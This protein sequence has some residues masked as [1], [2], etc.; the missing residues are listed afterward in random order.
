M[1][2]GF[3]SRLKRD[4]ERLGLRNVRFDWSHSPP[5]IIGTLRYVT[6]TQPFA[7]SRSQWQRAHRTALA[8]L[9]RK[10]ASTLAGF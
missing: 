2:E 1:R 5:L 9:S 3:P 10:I 8:G 7:Y 6:I 4:A